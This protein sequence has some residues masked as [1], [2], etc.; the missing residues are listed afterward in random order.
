MTEI[1][2]YIRPYFGGTVEELKLINSFF[3]LVALEKGSFFQKEGRYADK[4]GFV[5][6]GILREYTSWKILSKLTPLRQFKMI[7]FAN[8]N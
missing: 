5:K 4:L 6:T 1:E 7:P 3:K 8:G 2:K